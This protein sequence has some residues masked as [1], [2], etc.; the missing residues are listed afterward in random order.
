MAYFSLSNNMAINPEDYETVPP[1]DPSNYEAVPQIDPSNY[2]V[3]SASQPSDI[4]EFKAVPEEGT[5]H[6]ALRNIRESFS[7]V[8]GPTENQR[9]ER[10]AAGKFVGGLTGIA[11]EDIPTDKTATEG[12]IPAAFSNNAPWAAPVAGEGVR[13]KTFYGVP[14]LET[15]GQML[16]TLGSA[17]KEDDPESLKIA[18]SIYGPLAGVYNAITS[19]T[20]VMTMGLGGAGASAKAVGSE[21]GELASGIDTTVKTLFATDMGRAAIEN[22][23]KAWETITDPKADVSDKLQASLEFTINAGFAALAGH[24]AYKDVKAESLNG[25]TP[26]AQAKELADAS[27]KTIDE[28]GKDAAEAVKANA[29]NADLK[30][31][32]ENIAKTL[33]EQAGKR[34]EQKYPDVPFPKGGSNVPIEIERADG[35]RYPATINGYWPDGDMP[36]I[37][38]YNEEAGG[39]SHGM[40]HEGEKIVSEV[41]TP[42]DFAKRANVTV[43]EMGG[44]RA[45]QVDVPGEGGRPAFSGSPEEAEAAGYRMDIPEGLPEGTHTVDSLPPVVGKPSLIPSAQAM[46]ISP[47]TAVG[48]VILD[49]MSK[50]TDARN[51]LIARIKESAP[52]EK[53]ASTFDA[54]NNIADI[55]ARQKAKL[56]SDEVRW[57]TD[58]KGKTLITR[59]AK[60]SD[61]GEQAIGALVEAGISKD[62]LIEN[63]DRLAAARGTDLPFGE[64]KKWREA[65]QYALDNFDRLKETAEK[66]VS[67][68]K[69]QVQQENGVGIDTAYRNDYV[70]H[71]QDVDEG[72]NTP[73]TGRDTGSTNF[74]QERSFDTFTDSLLAGVKPKTLNAI[75]LL[76][77]RI[78]KGQRMI[79]RRLW[80]TSA[81]DIIDPASQKPIVTDLE[82]GSRM[83]A[84][85]ENGGNKKI[86]TQTPPEGYVKRQ[87][88]GEDIAVHEGYAGLFDS[89]LDPSIL[90]RN[91]MGALAKKSAMF[92]K[93]AKLAIDTFHPSRMAI[94]LTSL[95]GRPTFKKGLWVLD[96]SIEGIKA[97]EAHG[98][99]PKGAAQWAESIKPIVDLLHVQGLNV[100]KI[101]DN[102]HADLIHGLPGLRDMQR[103]TFDRLVRGSM[104]TAAVNEFMRLK[105]LMPELT[106]EQLARKI[107]KDI[108]TRFG[109]L[110]NQGWIKNKTFRDIANFL[111]LAPQWNESLLRAEYGT[112]KQAGIMAI[113]AATK[114]RIVAGTLLKSSGTLV[115]GMFVAN[116][117]INQITRGNFTWENP[118]E[119]INSKISAWIPSPFG[120]GHGLFL[121]PLSLPLEI[122]HQLMERIEKTTTINQAVQDVLSYKL[123][124]YGQAIQ[125]FITKKDINGTYNTDWK[126]AM[127]MA[128]DVLPLPM[129]TDTALRAARSI[130]SGKVT[131]SFPNQI[132]KQMLASFGLKTSAAPSPT[133]RMYALAR[134]WKDANGI[135]ETP[136]AGE[137]TYTK[138][139]HALETGN[140]DDESNEMDKLLKERT[141]QQVMSYFTKL[142]N[143][144]FTGSKQNDLRFVQTLS[145]E[146]RDALTQA[147]K[148]RETMAV[149]AIQLL[150][151][152]VQGKPAP[153]SE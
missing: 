32:N 40:L 64:I 110:G 98:E 12:F 82:V 70:Y 35:T 28:V 120:Q 121:N 109:S 122:G 19:P 144:A 45:V 79:N 146:Q 47:G 130:M 91:Y 143:R 103:F 101:T 84:D 139:L 147:R 36:S 112:Y 18:K 34:I 140:D 4:P 104:E 29:N 62:K 60:R 105:K 135:Q 152:K 83:A 43:M 13:K 113:D 114:R 30:A 26:E 69:D 11:P 126:L 54:A 129:Q 138:M 78:A 85:L 123:S 22:A 66:Y 97:M 102:M 96:N 6:K 90:D 127:A 149:R 3:V 16:D 151:K 63:I 59:E 86:T 125:T 44:K 148:D 25:K 52:K 55:T 93:Q 94:M 7:G 141:P 133:Q 48:R 150:G 68:T 67:M 95:I 56:L 2:E 53:I 65:N 73:F 15:A 118:E 108:N 42:E 142:P 72:E 119:G 31:A 99:L 134:A 24:G 5:V 153:S 106:D 131:E 100:G 145:P 81:R 61:I 27:G 58:T 33:S 128:K 80:A 17:K 49:G 89:L 132:G 88:G 111:F 9:L 117:I 137:G 87:I 71:M 75:T 92:L 107:A 39:W 38:R 77:Q 57:E 20:S 136:I 23:P 10:E 46:G 116:Q 115:A 21:A 74:K 1:L 124:G 41:P 51:F 14:G 8:I 76:E 50:L 37:G